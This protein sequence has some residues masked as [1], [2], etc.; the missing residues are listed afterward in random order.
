MK[1]YTIGRRFPVKNNKGYSL[2]EVLIVVALIGVILSLIYSLAP[3]SFKHFELQR[4]KSNI[5]SDMRLAMSY[6]TKE[7]RKSDGVEVVNGSLV[8]DGSLIIDDINFTLENNAFKKGDK[9][10]VDL[11]KDIKVNKTESNITIE[12]ITEDKKGK[13]HSIKSVINIR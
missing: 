6:L 8:E 1:L 13:Q 12:I 10:I 11:I 5:I 4:E 2:I 3:K 7:I 9:T